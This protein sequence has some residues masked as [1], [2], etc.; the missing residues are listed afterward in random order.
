M[1]KELNEITNQNRVKSIEIQ[2]S[3]RKDTSTYYKQII[4]KS[5][6]ENIIL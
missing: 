4:W 6:Q 2:Q 1:K 5:L 3:K